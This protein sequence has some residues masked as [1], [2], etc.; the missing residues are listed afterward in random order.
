MRPTFK[1][2][3]VFLAILCAGIQCVRPARTNPPTDPALAL[4]ARHVPAD[5]ATILDRSCRDCHSN[6]TR[7]PW[8]SNVAPT[9]WL[10]A[11]DVQHGREHFNYSQWTSI[12]EDE[13]DSLLGGICSLTQRERM[14]LPPYVLLHRGAK[15]S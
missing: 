10:V 1:L 5:V 6:E 15:L 8:Y 12:E 13:Q 9:S 14:P 3:L 11:N 4:N 2:L 7:W